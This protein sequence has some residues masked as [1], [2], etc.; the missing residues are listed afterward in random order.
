MPTIHIDT[1]PFSQGEPLKEVDFIE[2]FKPAGITAAQASGFRAKA[3]AGGTELVV[4]D[5][6]DL[7]TLAEALVGFTIRVLPSD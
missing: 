2:A 7:R 4:P 5:K 1:D 3:L 6:L